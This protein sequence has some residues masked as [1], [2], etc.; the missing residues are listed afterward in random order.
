MKRKTIIING[1]KKVPI[2][3]STV[4]YVKL[5]HKDFSNIEYSRPEVKEITMKATQI[6]FQD[7]I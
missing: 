7:T 2:Y 1:E 4:K 5:R 6:S 3:L